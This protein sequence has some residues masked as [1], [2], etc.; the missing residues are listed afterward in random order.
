MLYGA[1][2][3]PN[4]QKK[5]S[6]ISINKETKSTWINLSGYRLMKSGN[7]SIKLL[8][9]NRYGDFT[10]YTLPCSAIKF[11]GFK[12]PFVLSLCPPLPLLCDCVWLSYLQRTVI[13]CSFFTTNQQAQY[14]TTHLDHRF[15]TRGIHL[16][17]QIRQIKQ[18]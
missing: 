14:R 12:E 7:N 15:L 13:K 11:Q 16:H 3:K 18:K 10:F 1:F 17:L 2:W 6:A 4:K 9:Y 8:G 5:K